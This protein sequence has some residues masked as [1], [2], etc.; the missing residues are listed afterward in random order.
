MLLINCSTGMVAG[1]GVALAV[2]VSGECI[3]VLEFGGM[4]GNG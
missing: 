3:G 2:P 4:N 1:A